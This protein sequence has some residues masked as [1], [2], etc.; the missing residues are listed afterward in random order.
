MQRRKG[1]RSSEQRKLER[2]RLDRN[3]KEAVADPD[4]LPAAGPFVILVFG[5][6]DRRAADAVAVTAT[7]K[8]TSASRTRRAPIRGRQTTDNPTPTNAASVAGPSPA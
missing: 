3:E 6:F 4:V 1:A 8:P 2:F 5:A 7:V